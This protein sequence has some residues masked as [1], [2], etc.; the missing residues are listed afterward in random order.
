MPISE[1][2]GKPAP[3]SL[4]I[5]V[6][7]L[8]SAYYDN[9]PDPHDPAQRVSFGTS[10]HRGTSLNCSFNEDHILAISQAI[11]EYRHSQGYS[12]PLFVGMDTHA[13]SRPA[14]STAVEVFA[15]NGV[16]VMLQAGQ[17]Y[18]PTPV[19]SHAILTY[20]RGRASGLADGVVI[21]PSHNPPEDGGFKYN[22]PSGGPA[23]TTTTRVI[24][25]RANAILENG[26]KDVRRIP[27]EKAMAAGTTHM[28]DYI[29][30]Y[31]QD[32]RNVVDM[33]AMAAAGLKIGVDPLGGSSLAFWDPIAGT[34]GLDLELVN[35]RVDPTFS[36]MTV[37]HDG[38]I[39]MDCSS[40][41]AM[42]GLIRL[43]DRFDIAFGTDPDADRHGIVTRSAGLLQPNHYLT[44]AIWYLYQH[45]PE[46]KVETAVGKTLVS[47]SMI[48][49]VTDDLGRRLYE[50]PVGFKWFVDGLLE[51]WLGFG[52]EESAGASFLRRDGT[53][54]TTDK[55]GILL[56]L[57]AVE[58]MVVTG[59]DPAEHYGRLE[60]QFGHSEYERIDAPATPAQK[61]V[62][63]KLSPD[64]VMAQDL[65]G[66]PIVAKLT[67]APGNDAPIGGL[68]VVAANSWFAARPSGTE[69]VYKV[70]AES[71]LGLDHLRRVQQEAQEIVAEAFRGAGG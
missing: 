62:L 66:E 35:R 23:D 13:L 68:K 29:L 31:V 53:V 27:L 26:V 42:A 33:P 54:W 6:S 59:H 37:D 50:V 40:P 58:I 4:L 41:Y 32:L 34:Y 20:N 60:E 22:P 1:L 64:M 14:L 24:Q 52:G 36:F 15:A 57:L 12:G 48:D 38:Q 21:T 51:G 71:F 56:D 17:G 3:D 45:R 46:W 49:R 67:R 7:Q 5:N 19:I 43:K 10:G 47:S 25:D 30:P 63:A 39:R 55:D 2:A 69:D 44:A 28:H 8:V 61:A 16:D 18:T 11:C 70:Y 65:A 9:R